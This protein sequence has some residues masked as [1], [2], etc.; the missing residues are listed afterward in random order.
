M[1]TSALLRSTFVHGR[2]DKNGEEYL[3]L[4]YFAAS[5]LGEFLEVPEDQQIWSWISNH[6]Q[7]YGEA[8]ASST[9]RTLA[10]SKGEDATLSRIGILD[11]LVKSPDQRKPL[12]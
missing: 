3:N 2:Y 5:G 7:K 10:K 12:K 9:L 6:A 4:R 1:N 11:A 8:P